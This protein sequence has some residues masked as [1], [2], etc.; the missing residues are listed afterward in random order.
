[1]TEIRKNITST[2]IAAALA[3][4]GFA[5]SGPAH[6]AGVKAGTLNCDVERGWGFVFGSSKNLRCVFSEVN[7][8]EEHYEG[9]VSKFGVDIGYTHGGVLIWEV[10]APNA[11]AGKGALQGG[12][13]GL[14]ASG[15]VGVG[16]GAHALV[17]GFH[18]SITLQPI[19][20]SGESGLNVAA[21]IAALQLKHVD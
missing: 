5:L 1:M 18:K 20:I 8:E 6:A 21:G 15:A 7:G 2:V 17:G 10:I 4:S 14:T 19:S 12:Y 3:I 16:A 9:T 11:D 13:A